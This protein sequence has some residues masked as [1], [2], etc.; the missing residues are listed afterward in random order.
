MIHRNERIL[1]NIPVGSLGIIPVAGCEEMG[2]RVIDYI[3][4]WRE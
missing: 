3:V 2:N 1:N 4:I